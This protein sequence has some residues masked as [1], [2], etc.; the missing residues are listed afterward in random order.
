MHRHGRVKLV[1]W[2]SISATHPD[3]FNHDG[4]HLRPP[5]AQAYA[6]LLQAAM[7]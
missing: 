5:G 7:Q 1:D 6:E 2:L 3:W 4:F